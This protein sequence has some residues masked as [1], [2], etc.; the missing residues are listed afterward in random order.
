M[1]RIELNLLV[2]VVFL[3][4]GIATAVAIFVG[5]MP[6]WKYISV[7]FPLIAVSMAIFI[8][9]KKIT[10]K[11]ISFIFFGC[12]LLCIIFGE[13]DNL[14]GVYFLFLA[15]S[16][17]VTPKYIAISAS[18]SF[19]TILTTAIIKEWPMPTSIIFIMGY[20]GM[21][22][23]AWAIFYPKS[24][25]ITSKELDDETLDILLKLYKGRNREET[26]DDLSINPSTVTDKMKK[27]RS[28]MEARSNIELWE[29][30]R[31]KGYIS[32]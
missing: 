10:R 16:T 15:Y 7:S 12:S 8:F 1:K 32:I 14:S 26:A 23:I 19:L 28:I 31:Q 22:A 27:A 3:L 11:I 6:W 24:P 25:K 30:L 2:S 20:C 5:G 13:Y 9:K 18:L 21:L 29:K 17:Y 4:V